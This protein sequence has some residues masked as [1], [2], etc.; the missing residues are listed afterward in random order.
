MN[1]SGYQF[2][3]EGDARSLRDLQRALDDIGRAIEDYG[4]V[5]QSHGYNNFGYG[6]EI[7][8]VSQEELRLQKNLPE[9]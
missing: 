9:G 8:Q 1:R 4:P 7:K 5:S 2:K 3:I 6:I